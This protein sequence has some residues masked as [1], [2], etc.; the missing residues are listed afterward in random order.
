MEVAIHP[1]NELWNQGARG[2][3]DLAAESVNVPMGSVNGAIG[4]AGES[5]PSPR[6]RP[7]PPNLAPQPGYRTPNTSVPNTV[8]PGSAAYPR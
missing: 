2:T 4:G 8:R 7:A 3:R 6:P 5:E 1:D